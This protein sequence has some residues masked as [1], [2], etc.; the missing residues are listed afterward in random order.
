MCTGV[1]E[2][3]DVGDDAGQEFEQAQMFAEGDAG[4]AFGVG[5][6]VEGEGEGDGEFG[7]VEVGD[8]VDERLLVAAVYV[9][10]GRGA[11]E[12]DDRGVGDPV[13]AGVRG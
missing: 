1:E 11:A 10:E 7:F 6:A 3:L 4:G 13:Q 8:V 5:G 12:S 2:V 9:A